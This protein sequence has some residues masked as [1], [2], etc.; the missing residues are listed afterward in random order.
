MQTPESTAGGTQPPPPTAIPVE[1]LV[2]SMK[3]E[4][5]LVIDAGYGAGGGSVGGG[6]PAPASPPSAPQ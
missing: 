5:P 3:P 2:E 4:Q 6:G 1:K